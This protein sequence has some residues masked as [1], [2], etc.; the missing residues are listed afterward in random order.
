MNAKPFA[1]VALAILIAGTAP[2][3]A[4]KG[5]VAR[6]DFDEGQGAV[7]HDTSGNANHGTIHGA[8][9]PRRWPM[10]MARSGPEAAGKRRSLSARGGS[11]TQSRRTES[12]WWPLAGFS[13]LSRTAR[14]ERT[15]NLTVIGAGLIVRS[16]GL[17]TCGATRCRGVYVCDPHEEKGRVETILAAAHIQIRLAPGPSMPGSHPTWSPS[18]VRQGWPKLDRVPVGSYIR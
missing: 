5:L 2:A 10:S 9:T 12:A 4:E 1:M 11:S 13:D 15:I 17:A 16:P 3:A 18:P 7:L 6:W 14:R 8:Q